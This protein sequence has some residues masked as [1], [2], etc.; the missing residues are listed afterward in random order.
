MRTAG[1]QEYIWDSCSPFLTVW[2]ETLTPELSCSRICI[3]WAVMLDSLA[4]INRRK[5]SFCGVV[6]R[7][8]LPRVGVE[9]FQ[10]S[11][12]VVVHDVLFG[13]EFT[14]L[15]MKNDACS[16]SQIDAEL[17]VL[18]FIALT[19]CQFHPYNPN[20]SIKLLRKFMAAQ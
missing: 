17:R 5:R 20:Y 10:R 8:L 7:C 16:D 13:F 14:I 2:S 12:V 9:H 18:S 15:E 4:A 6:I 1:R 11:E 3:L 19:K